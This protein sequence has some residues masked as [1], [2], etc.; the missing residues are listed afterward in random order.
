MASTRNKNTVGNYNLEQRQF[1]NYQQY[2]LYK[3]SSYGEANTTH[4]AGNG[5][6]GGRLPMNQLSSNPI[7]IE[8]QLF[9]INSTN[10]VNPASPVVPLLNKL[11][12]LNLFQKSPTIMPRP[13]V[14]DKNR[15]FPLG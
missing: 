3:N 9:G 15:P 11:E 2:N 14:I 6:L 10:L 12:T 8:S 7:E 5:L 13:L 4:L 1:M